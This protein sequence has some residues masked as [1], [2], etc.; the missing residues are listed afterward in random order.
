M[1][2]EQ[3]IVATTTMLQMQHDVNV[4]MNKTEDWVSLNRPWY[5]AIWTEAVRLLQSGL[6]GNGGRKGK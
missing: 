2:I 3:A 1:K 6:I 5:R 4:V